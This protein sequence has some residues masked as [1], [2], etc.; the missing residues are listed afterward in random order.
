[1]LAKIQ[2]TKIDCPHCKTKSVEFRGGSD[3]EATWTDLRG[4]RP[5]QYSDALFQCGF[6]G[7][8]V[9][10]RFKGI[11]TGRNS[12]RARQTDIM[13]PKYRPK[14]APAHTPANAVPF[15]DQGISSLE[16]ENY[17]AAGVMLRKS[18]EV[19]LKTTISNAKGNL[20]NLI[21]Q[22]GSESKLTDQMVDW[23]Q[24]IRE[25]GNEAAHDMSPWTK[26]EAEELLE[27]V[28]LLFIYLF[29]LP[30]RTKEARKKA[31]SRKKESTV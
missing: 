25:L 14:K 23:A 18:L 28:E 10:I 9:I 15:F 6:C 11:N 5:I 16:N 21:V 4:S 8:G 30:E 17:D 3:K 13:F 7:R 20:Y 19:A 2:V 22:A 1:M 29:A 27:F 31:Q 26:A 12:V 24:T